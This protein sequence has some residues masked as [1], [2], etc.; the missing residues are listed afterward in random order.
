MIMEGARLFES[1][2][3][4]G[5]LEKWEVALAADPPGTQ[6]SVLLCNKAMALE[7]IGRAAEAVA[8]YDASLAI[9]DKS[10]EALH[11]RG[12][13]LKALKKM[14]EALESFDRALAVK[15]ASLMTM[16]GRVDALSQLGRFD[17]A[18]AAAT[19][20]IAIQPDDP[21]GY[22][23]RG[24]AYLKLKRFADAITDVEMALTLG[25]NAPNTKKILAVALSSRAVE[26]DKANDAKGAEEAFDRAIS[27]DPNEVALFNR[28][29]LYAR[30]GREEL[31]IVEFKRVAAMSPTNFPARSALGTLL[32]QRSNFP[33]A[34]AA[35]AEAEALDRSNTSVIYNL[36]AAYMQ[37]DDDAKAEAQF[38]KVL[39]ID[40][41]HEAAKT[42]L[43][44][45][46]ENGAADADDDRW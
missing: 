21:N 38:N 4:A 44:M 46:K 8:C 13:A 25:D 27:F 31:A 39:A 11:N 1:G 18:C 35:F 40:P 6:K 28:A 37:M 14:A 22:T 43:R 32:L 3:Y 36:G 17:D 2:D 19:D 24:F 10:F 23:D 7:R 5:A 15:P 16:R 45:M 34:A 26:L 20:Y 9:N 30:T 12:V 29:Y 42:A 33:E 41:T